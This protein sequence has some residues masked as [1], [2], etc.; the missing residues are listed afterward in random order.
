MWSVPSRRSDSSTAPVTT[1]AASPS[2]DAGGCRTC[3]RPGPGRG[4][5]ARA[6][7]RRRSSRR[8]RRS[9]CPRCRPARLRR[10]RRRR[11][12]P[13]TRQHRCIIPNVLVP[14]PSGSARS[15]PQ[16][17]FEAGAVGRS[18]PRFDMGHTPPRGTDSPGVVQWELAVADRGSQPSLTGLPRPDS[19]KSLDYAGIRRPGTC[20]GRPSA[21]RRRVPG[22]A[23]AATRRCRSR[24]GGRPG[25][26][27]GRWSPAGAGRA[28][29]AAG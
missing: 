1:E 19:Q 17:W 18:F 6:S 28:R 25:R 29:P 4:C 5:P 15:A 8:R 22:G 16:G 13:A 3:S 14:S 26:P 23:G 2:E 10:P 24:R 11:G 21:R 20:A 7:S 27:A 12:R 9:R